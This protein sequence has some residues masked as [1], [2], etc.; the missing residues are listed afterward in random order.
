[1]FKSLSP[2]IC[3][4][5]G[6]TDIY[7]IYDTG[8]SIQSDKRSFRSRED[9]EEYIRSSKHSYIL[10]M[11]EKYINKQHQQFSEFKTYNTPN[12]R[13]SLQICLTHLFSFHA[14][15]LHPLCK[16]ILNIEA[17]LYNL[18]PGPKS[19]SYD[20]SREQLTDILLFCKSELSPL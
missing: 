19:Y 10:L 3:P 15:S 6:I 18:L 11:I 1:M 12:K 14:L 13:H 7:L 16:S 20:Q 4:V 9:A 2:V 17:D 5:S 8:N